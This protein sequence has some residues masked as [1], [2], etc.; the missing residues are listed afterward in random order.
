MNHGAAGAVKSLWARFNGEG[1]RKVTW[2]Q[3]FKNTVTYSWLNCLLIFVPAAWTCYLLNSK[4]ILG[5]EA[6]FVVFALSFLAIIPLNELM[7]YAGGEMALYCGKSL[8]DL[9]VISCENTV[10]AVLAIVLLFRCEL[11]LLQSTIIGVCLLHLLLIPGMAFMTNGARVMELNLDRNRTTMNHTLLTIGVLTLM[12]PASFFAALDRGISPTI[13]TASLITD[14]TRTSLVQISRGLA[15]MLLL[16]YICSRIFLHN[17]PALPETSLKVEMAIEFILEEE[18]LAKKNPEVNSWFC[19]T[20]LVTLVGLLAFTAVILL[21]SIDSLREIGLDKH[22]EWFGLILLPLCSFSGDAVLAIVWYARHVVKYW[23]GEPSAIV[24]LA[25]TKSID[26]SIQFLMFWMPVLV[27]LGWATG[28]PMSLLFDFFE[29]ALLLGACFLVNHVTADSK[30]NWGEG[31]ALVAFYIM[32]GLTTFFYT[33]QPEV[34]DLLSCSSVA[35]AIA[36]GFGTSTDL[37]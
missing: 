31:A 25:E 4:K 5:P 23:F 17:P 10:E 21:D 19:L 15:I 1:R 27:L 24:T 14:Q 29:V 2:M 18:E 8:G 37:S 26:A 34:K 36:N 22:D 28:R 9:V 11:K 16:V 33:G 20:L 12:L 13:T 30:T 3:S 32:I 6:N 7:E 35:N